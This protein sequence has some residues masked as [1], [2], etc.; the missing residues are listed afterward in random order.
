MFIYP[1]ISL[2][3]NVTTLNE[4]LVFIKIAARCV[5]VVPLAESPLALPLWPPTETRHY[6]VSGYVT[7]MRYPPKREWNYSQ[8]S[9]HV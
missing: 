9:R 3:Y 5:C 7:A 8:F 6:A 4:L 1:V 2:I